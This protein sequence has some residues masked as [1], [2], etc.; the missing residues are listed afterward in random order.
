MDRLRI[1]ARQ[2]FQVDPLPPRKNGVDRQR[3]NEL[4]HANRDAIGP[5]ILPEARATAAARQPSASRPP[6]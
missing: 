2:G 1:Q 5:P 4:D 3:L 6:R